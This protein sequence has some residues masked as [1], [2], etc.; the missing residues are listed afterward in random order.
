MERAKWQALICCGNAYRAAHFR[1]VPKEQTVVSNLVSNALESHAQVFPVTD[2]GADQ[3][4]SALRVLATS[5]TGRR[6]I[7]RR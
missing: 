2:R 3:S 1:G 7:Q 4:S 6:L 5:E